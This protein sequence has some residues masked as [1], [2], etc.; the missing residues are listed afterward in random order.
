MWNIEVSFIITAILSVVG[1]SRTTNNHKG[2]LGLFA[3]WAVV[4]GGVAYSGF[5]QNTATIPPRF[6]WLIIPTFTFTVVAYRWIDVQDVSMKWLIAIHVIRIPVELVLYQLFLQGLIP[7]L[8]TFKGWNW[9]ILSGISACL[10]LWLYANNRATKNLL[11]F[12]NWAALV[13]LAVIVGSAILSAPTPIQQFAFD[14][15]N[16]AVLRFPFI[17]LPAV[18]VPIVLLSHLLIFKKLAD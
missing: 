14:Q 7:E 6:V 18:V 1:L 2:V 12:W 15:P 11:L 4:I 3:A 8:M 9:D 10:I 17:W 5:F 13:L 16:V